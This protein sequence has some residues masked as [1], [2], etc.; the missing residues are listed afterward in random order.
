MSS[1]FS[2]SSG[3]AVGTAG[4]ESTVTLD[5]TGPEST[6]REAAAQTGTTLI[7]WNP[8]G[9]AG[10]GAGFDGWPMA[11]FSGPRAAVATLLREY[12]GR[13]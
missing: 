12:D 4:P 2:R 6:A 3:H 7:D 1:H 10:T 8:K 11:T 9:V 13:A 5:W